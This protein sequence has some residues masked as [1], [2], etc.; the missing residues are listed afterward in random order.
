MNVEDTMSARYLLSL[1]GLALPALSC[2]GGA[3]SSVAGPVDSTSTEAASIAGNPAVLPAD[4]PADWYTMVRTRI[5]ASSRAFHPSD[6]RSDGFDGFGASF[7]SIGRTARFDR[8][9]LVLQDSQGAPALAIRTLAIGRGDDVEPAGSAEPAFGACTDEVGV[10]GTCLRRLELTRPHGVTEWWITLENGLEQGWTLASPPVGQGDLTFD[11]AI[12]EALSVAFPDAE[13]GGA[14]LTITDGLGGVWTVAGVVAT[15]ARGEALVAWLETDG[16]DLR[17]RVD[18]E[19]AV[20]PVTVDPVYTT[21]AWTLDGATGHDQFGYALD[22]AGDVNG[23]GYDDVIIG[24]Y[25]SASGAAYIFHGSPSGLGSTAAVTLTSGTSSDDFGSAVAGIGDVN[26]DGYDDV[27]VGAFAYSSTTGRVTVYHGSASGILTDAVTTLTGVSTLGRFGY[28]VAGGRDVTG[29]GYDDLLVGASYYSSGVGRVYLYAGSASGITT[30]ATATWTGG[31]SA[32][33]GTSVAMLGDVNGDGHPDASFAGTSN[34]YVYHGTGTGLASTPATTISSGSYVAP[35]GDVEGDGYDDLALATGSYARV[36]RGSSSGISSAS[37]WS[38]TATTSSSIRSARGVGDFDGDGYDDL[39]VGDYGYS[40]YGGAVYLFWGSIAG[41]STS[42][43]VSMTDTSTTY[44]QGWAVAGAG[45][46]N[47]DGRADILF[48]KVYYGTSPYAGEALACHGGARSLSLAW[49]VYGTSDAALGLSVSDAGDVNGDGYDDV[50]VGAPTFR[51]QLGAAY[52]YLGSSSGPGASASASMLGATP[53]NKFGYAVTGA[54]DVNHDGYADVAVGAP[55]YRSSYGRV[56]VYHGSAS[57]LSTSPARTLTGDSS[58]W[59]GFSVS[60]AGDVNHDGYHDLIVGAIYSSSVSGRTYVYHGSAS[61]LGSTATTTLTGSCQFGYSVA[62]A[63][64]VN[65]DSYDDVIVGSYD[66][67]SSCSTG[68]AYVYRGSSSG[69]SST[70]LRTLTGFASSD[71]FG[72]SVSGAG[73]VN[74]D[75]YDDVIIGAPGYTSST[76][77]AYLYLGSS[78]GPASSPTSLITGSATS[79][80]L[81]TS[82]SGA[83]DVDGDGY[84]DVIIGAYGTSSYRGSAFLCPGSST[85]FSSSTC[86]TLTGSASSDAFG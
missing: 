85:G 25:D 50:I 79:D 8:D 69:I 54:G 41:L 2:G 37:S 20:Y 42:S 70:A 34:T 7:H 19:G 64:D 51:G 58:T 67:S 78:S 73:D 63:G 26:G 83:G 24:T 6:P 5:Q 68:N 22:T 31:S 44:R 43:Y 56:Y 15:D 12:D 3:D 11:V 40:S 47:G 76:G 14:S 55:Y 52:L 35:A 23:D 17:V 21:A 39:L 48:S 1:V 9:G 32:S 72:K 36:Y 84:D 33:L 30:T 13:D 29:D 62:G 71:Y 77:R 80:Y 53:G 45:D 61:G 38:L 65:G 18:D 60:G 82:V 49:Y 59:F 86:T 16:V 57:G 74:G 66:T 4:A 75:G 28:S 27:A 46:V 10:D 81:G